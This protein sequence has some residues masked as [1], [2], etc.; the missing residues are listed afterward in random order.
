MGHIRIDWRNINNPDDDTLESINDEIITVK[1]FYCNDGQ[2]VL[3]NG[4]HDDT[5]GIQAAINSSKVGDTIYFPPG[6]YMISSPLV[7]LPNR[8]YK[9]SGWGSIVKQMNN[10]NMAQMIQFADQ[11]SQHENVFMKDLLFDGNKANNPTGTVGLFLFGL[12]NSIFYRIKIQNCSGTG[13]FLE[14]NASIQSSTNHFVDCW[15]FSNTGYGV[16]FSGAC[17]DNHIIGGDFGAN[18][19]CALYLAGVSSSVRDATFWGS[20]SASGVII[21]GVSNQLTGNNIEG[22]AGHGVEVL[23]SHNFIAAN[24]IYDNA[25]VPSAY[26]QK[27]GIYVNGTSGAYVENVVIEGNTIYSGLYANTG[28][29][30]YGINLD[31]YHKNCSVF[32]N[33]PRYNGNGVMDNSRVAVNGLVES[34]LTDYSWTNSQFQCYISSDTALGVGSWSGL[35]LTKVKDIENEFSGTKFTPKYR[36]LYQFDVS[37]MLNGT[38]AGLR[39]L[40]ILKNGVT[41]YRI[42]VL[43]TSGTGWQTIGGSTQIPLEKGDY[44]EV[45]L[46]TSTTETTMSGESF[47]RITGKLLK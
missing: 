7:I 37:I 21:A 17:A 47:T 8:T 34:D 32:G 39:Q 26:G 42:G 36:G 14:G 11:A 12:L 23:A 20:Q 18:W 25:N 10:K 22:H 45:Q 29:H 16:Y 35:T 40:R 31:T 19:N 44:I 2:F 1:S 30:R 5:S 15:A 33:S 43:T 46:Y 24:K 4:V 27:D 3:G 28:Y 13:L 9:G 6:T 41:E 38:T